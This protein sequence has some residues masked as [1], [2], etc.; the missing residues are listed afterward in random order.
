LNFYSLHVSLSGYN[1]DTNSDDITVASG[2]VAPVMSSNNLNLAVSKVSSVNVNQAVFA[3]VMSSN[4][5]NQ[6]ASVMSSI[7]LNQ[8]VFALVMS[9]SNLNLAASV[10]PSTHIWVS[11][12]PP[13]KLARLRS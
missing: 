7:D 5:R 1:Y 10:M 2:H 8:T 13:I 4:Y 3:S 11:F 9:S 6:A 12:K